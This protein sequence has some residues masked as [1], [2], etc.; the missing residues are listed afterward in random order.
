MSED[1]DKSRKRAFHISK[2]TI[3]LVICC[4][5]A[6]AAS[7]Y[8]FM[9]YQE[10]QNTEASANAKIV[11]KVGKTIELPAEA[12][13]LVTVADKSK[14]TNKQ[15]AT[16]VENDDI[17]LIFAKAKRLVVYRPS[18]DKVADILSFNATEELQTK[19]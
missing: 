1:N 10:S 14:L 11:E 12:P 8:F 16:K 6:I 19:K 3:T 17:M 9:K 15:L 13:V 5:I 2:V 18:T 7:V 4:I